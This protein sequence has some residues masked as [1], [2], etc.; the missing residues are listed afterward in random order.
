VVE[1]YR[2]EGAE[3]LL[4]RQAKFY[5]G[6][7]RYFGDVEPVENRAKYQGYMFKVR[8]TRVSKFG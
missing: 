6:K 7:D 3:A 2:K 8:P 5:L 1:D 4:D